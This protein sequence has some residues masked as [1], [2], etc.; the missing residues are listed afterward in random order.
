MTF[1]ELNK[2][3]ETQPIDEKVFENDSHLVTS[4]ISTFDTAADDGKAQAL[5]DKT[6]FET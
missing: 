4:V 5:E 6:L 3:I 2:K 1:L